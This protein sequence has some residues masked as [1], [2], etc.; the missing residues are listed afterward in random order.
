ME[1]ISRLKILLIFICVLVFLQGCSETK[2]AKAPEILGTPSGYALIDVLYEYEFGADGGD[3][4][5]SYSITSGPDWLKIENLN[6]AKPAFRVYGVPTVADRD[7]FNNFVPAAFDYDITVTDGTLSTTQT[8]TVQLSKNLLGFQDGGLVATEGKVFEELNPE[9]FSDGCEL[10]SMAPREINGKT[11]YPHPVIMQLGAPAETAIKLHYVFESQYDENKKERDPSN[12][13]KARPNVDFDDRAGVYTVEPGVTR[14]AFAIHFFDDDIIEGEE[15]YRIV[16]DEILSGWTTYTEQEFIQIEDDEPAVEFLSETTVMSFDD[17]REYK[18]TLSEPVDYPLNIKLFV[19]N[20]NASNIT[21]ADYDITIGSQV[22]DAN[23]DIDLND[24]VITFPPN[25]T[26]AFFKLKVKDDL[27]ATDKDEIVIVKT[28]I[29]PIFNHQPVSVTINEWESDVTIAGTGTTNIAGEIAVQSDLS[30]ITML[31]S[32]G[33]DSDV[34]ITLSGRDGASG[35]FLSGGDALIASN[36]AKPDYI[37]GLEYRILGDQYVIAALTTEGTFT[38]AVNANNNNTKDVFL[39]MFTRPEFVA[40]GTGY[41]S[42][43][44]YQFGTDKDDVVNGV[45]FDSGGNVYVFGYTYGTFPTSGHVNPNGKKDGFIAK[46]GAAGDFQWVRSI[47]SAGDDEIVDIAI[48]SSV[49]YAVGTT[50]GVL[51][52]SS[53]GLTDG[54]IVKYDSLGTKQDSVQ[55]GTDEHDNIT[56]VS[57]SLSE[58]WISGHSRGGVKVLEGEAGFDSSVTPATVDPFL[59]KTNLD[60]RLTAAVQFGD[61]LLDD[62]SVT[63]GDL[64][65]SVMMGSTTPGEFEVGKNLGGSDAV[66]TSVKTINVDSADLW[67]KQF[68]T[69]ADDEFIDVSLFGNR[70]RMVL[71]KTTALGSGQETYKLT[72][73]SNEGAQL[74]IPNDLPAESP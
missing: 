12:L 8:F 33:A 63:I 47:G 64:T 73:F 37:G 57:A 40:P 9:E 6:G 5:L 4:I 74:T 66:L 17:E 26:E 22:C 36:D 54:F 34:S 3:G 32:T 65:S 62:V 13:I 69:S 71:W 55:F 59:L 25:S 51:S 60:G 61:P 39:R 45:H 67:H 38:G 48:V 50:D 30:I 21:S 28:Y 68:G 42:P 35:S 31:Q 70:K 43:W 27:T 7:E 20:E 2:S 1:F 19:D 58:L 14:C 15:T 24:C 52:G 41:T 56:G 18:L 53:Q 23:M 44:S 46:V 16:F 72:P 10:P 29:A 11:A 49:V